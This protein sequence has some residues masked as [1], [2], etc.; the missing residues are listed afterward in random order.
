M[1]QKLFHIGVVGAGYFAQLHHRAWMKAS[2]AILGAVADRDEQAIS[3]P[4][5]P[6]YHSLGDMLKREKI[7]ILDIVTPPHTHK[8]IIK[9]AIASGIRKIICQKPFCHSLGEAQEV[10]ALAAKQNVD[11]I[12]HENFRF[13][14]WYR[15]LKAEIDKGELGQLYQFRFDLRPGDGRGDKAYLDRQPYFQK[16]PRFLVH[17]TAVHFLDL[18]TFLF[19]QPLS[20]YADLR[21]L[22]PVIAGEDAGIIIF[23]YETGMRAVFD[24]NRH[25]CHRSDNHRL[26]MGEAMFETQAA[27]FYLDGFGAVYKRGH[28]ASDKALILPAYEGDAFGG[29]CVS[30]LIQDA[31]DRWQ[32]GCA[33]EN[34]ACDYLAIL[35]LEEAVYESAAKGQKIKMSQKG[36]AAPLDG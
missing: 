36:G 35:A 28:L 21:K 4:D 16:M 26:T 14:P 19:G 22:N 32:E 25:A 20:V 33:P 23:E 27:S 18:F 15:F 13:Q 2:G 10:T 30:R 34:P 1:E 5:V 17:E 31:V 6:R 12:I 29:D 24:G 8:D 11:L 3:P 9:E 7:D